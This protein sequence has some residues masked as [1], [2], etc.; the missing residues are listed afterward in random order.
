MENCIRYLWVVLVL[1]KNKKFPQP[2]TR[3]DLLPKYF[4]TV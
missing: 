4:N 2:C 3:A 1:K